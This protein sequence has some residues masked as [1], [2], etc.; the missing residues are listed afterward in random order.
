VGLD[1]SLP[2]RITERVKQQDSIHDASS[3][4]LVELRETSAS[5]STTASPSA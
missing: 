1:Q 5:M 3:G 4:S 2:R